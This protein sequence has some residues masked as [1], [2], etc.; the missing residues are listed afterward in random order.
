MNDAGRRAAARAVVAHAVLAG[1]QP[2]PLRPL[3]LAVL[4]ASSAVTTA[5]LTLDTPGGDPSEVR[6]WLVE[7]DRA[8]DVLVDAVSRSEGS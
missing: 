3:V 8:L 6:R 1:H 7:A 5:R 2:P 4:D